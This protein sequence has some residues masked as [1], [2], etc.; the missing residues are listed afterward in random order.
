MSW[1]ISDRPHLWPVFILRAYVYSLLRD[2][3]A[4]CFFED[5]IMH[6]VKNDNILLCFNFVICGRNHMFIHVIA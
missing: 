6:F 2:G 4:D 1:K 3:E 5:M